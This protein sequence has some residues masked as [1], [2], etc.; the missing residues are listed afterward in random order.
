MWGDR[1]SAVAASSEILWRMI[2]RNATR[3]ATLQ[4]SIRPAH[5]FSAPVLIKIMMY[6]GYSRDGYSRD[7]YSQRGYSRDYEHDNSYGHYVRGH[8]SRDDGKQQMIQKLRTMMDESGNEQ[9]REAIRRC[10]AQLGNS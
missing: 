1:S 6:S 9:D 10:M 7:D 8:Y 5:T 3:C 2:A 4:T